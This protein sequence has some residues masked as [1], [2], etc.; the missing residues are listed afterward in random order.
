MKAGGFDA[1]FFAHQEEIDLC[2]RMQNA[3]YKILSCPGS[4]VYHIGGGT[5]SKDN[6]KKIYLN[7]RNN[8]IML[9]K[10]L[11]I[12]EIIWII[13]FR[14]AL[15]A[16]SAWKNLLSGQPSFFTAIMKAHFSFFGWL[17]NGRKSAII[18]TNNTIQPKGVYNGSVVWQHFVKGKSKFSEIILKSN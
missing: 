6:P 13:P 16:I 3:G 18:F 15:D 11:S 9:W 1:F 7:F 12:S 14:F 2:W 8:L 10:N 4:V 5:L 17:L